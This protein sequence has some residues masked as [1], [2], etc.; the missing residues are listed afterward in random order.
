MGKNTLSLKV[1]EAYTRDVGMCV[2]RIDYYS[3][4]ALNMSTG[5]MIY[6]I[7]KSLDMTRPVT[8]GR[9]STGCMIYTIRKHIWN[10][11]GRCPYLTVTCNPIRMIPSILPVRL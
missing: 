3:M 2:A 1:I 9:V 7:C 11:A 8:G 10:D 5:C 4:D 6:T